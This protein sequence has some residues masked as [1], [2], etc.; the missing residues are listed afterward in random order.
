MAV[1]KDIFAKKT[2]SAQAEPRPSDVPT[3]KV[4]TMR[5]Q[6]FSNNQIVQ[7][8]QRDRYGMDNISRAINQADAKQGV[9]ESQSAGDMMAEQPQFQRQSVPSG[10]QQGRPGPAP[11]P[12][13]PNMGAPMSMG[14]PVG[15]IPDM[16]MPGGMGNPDEERI[17]EIAEAIIDE[18]W[19]DLIENVNRILE[20]KDS[21]ES[22]LSKLEQKVGDVKDQFD[23]L[24]EGVLGKIGE[25]DK[26]IVNLGTEI[27]ALE[28]VFQKVLPGFVDNVNEL[29]RITSKMRTAEKKK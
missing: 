21:I 6:G 25:Y 23:K 29:S 17:Q 3:E 19:T 2:Q 5:T 22:R 15:G 10:M 8:L 18:K 11:G 16:G 1:L 13:N 27:Q 20:W 28:K 24:H 4:L 7:T 12:M 14:G 26:G 9:L